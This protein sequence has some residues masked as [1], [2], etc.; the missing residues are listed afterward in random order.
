LDQVK[1]LVECYSGSQYA[2]RPLALWWQGQR[3]S[4]TAVLERWRSPDATGFCVRTDLGSMFEL[5]Y[6]ELKDEWNIRSI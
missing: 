6:A 4:V 3:L 1:R 2:E 5:T